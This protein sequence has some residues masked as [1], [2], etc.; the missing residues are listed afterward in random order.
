LNREEAATLYIAY[1]EITRT[2]VGMI[3]HPETWVIGN[4]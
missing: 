4:K 3:N 2:I 1:D